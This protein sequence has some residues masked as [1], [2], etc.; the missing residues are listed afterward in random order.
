M[1]FYREEM[2]GV[3]HIAFWPFYWI[4]GYLNGTGCKVPQ[5]S[6]HHKSSTRPGRHLDCNV[7]RDKNS[8]MIILFFKKCK[9]DSVPT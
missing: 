8:H 1:Y 3:L 7:D 9:L 6:R 2:V 5:T 4:D